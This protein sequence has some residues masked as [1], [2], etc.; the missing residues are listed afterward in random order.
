MKPS[1][2][3]PLPSWIRTAVFHAGIGDPESSEQQSGLQLGLRG[4]LLMT[5]HAY[6]LLISLFCLQLDVVQAQS[7]PATPETKA[8]AGQQ[9]NAEEQRSKAEE[10]RSIFIKYDSI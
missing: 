10:Q 5:W 1:N 7:T 9:S 8:D 2:A 4:K 6:L 3:R